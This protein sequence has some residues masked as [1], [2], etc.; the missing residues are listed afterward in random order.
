MSSYCHNCLNLAVAH[1]TVIRVKFSSD[2]Q[3]GGTKLADFAVPAPEF[4]LHVTLFGE[5]RE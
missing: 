3:S 5:G 1:I 2:G 4:A